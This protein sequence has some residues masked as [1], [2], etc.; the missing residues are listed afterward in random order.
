MATYNGQSER[1]L[2]QFG[3][4][5]AGA[6]RHVLVGG[7][8][9]G[10]TLAAVLAHPG[11]ER[12]TVIEIEPAVIAWQR[13]YLAPWSGRALDDPRVSVIEADLVAWLAQAPASSYDAALLDIDNGPNWTVTPL[14][15]GLYADD[16]LT[17]LGRA[18]RPGGSVAFWSA[19]EDAAFEARLARHFDGV[20][21]RLVPRDR[22]E[23]DVIYRATRRRQHP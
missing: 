13:R 9:V 19:A 21:R 7:L 5:A 4:E 18:L 1:L 10:F 12:V 17:A 6:P 14:N 3:L 23:P 15:A 20:T 11:V 16:G 22:G 2:A 8:G